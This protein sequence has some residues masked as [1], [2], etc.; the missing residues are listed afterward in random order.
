M[1]RYPTLALILRYGGVGSSLLALLAAAVTIA[2]GYD[3]LGPYIFAIGAVIAGVVW[4]LA[5][6]YVELVTIVTEM[7]VPR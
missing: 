7:L 1:E 3:A 5:R 6:S 4:L 2:A